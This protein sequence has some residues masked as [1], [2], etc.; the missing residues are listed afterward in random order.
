V[1]LLNSRSALVTATSLRRYPFSRSYGVNLPSSLTRVLSNTLV[2][3]TCLPVSVCGTGSISISLEAFLDDPHPQ[4]ASPEGSTCSLS[5]FMPTDFPIGRPKRFNAHYQQSRWKLRPCLPITEYTG[6]GIS[7]VCPSPTSFD[8]GLGPTKLQRTSLPE[9]PLGFRWTGF[10]PV[11]S[12]LMLA[13]SLACS[14]PRLTLR[15][16][17]TGNAPLPLRT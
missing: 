14:P 2:F 3:S 7:T 10:S 12:L 15:L 16:R 13:F 1:F 5:G 11:L 9:E 4:V 17:P 6:H 8:L